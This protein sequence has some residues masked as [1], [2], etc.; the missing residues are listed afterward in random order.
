[1]NVTKLHKICK[2]NFRAS[3]E[4]YKRVLNN[5]PFGLVN[6]GL[7]EDALYWTII[8]DHGVTKKMFEY[9]SYSEAQITQMQLIINDYKEKTITVARRYGLKLCT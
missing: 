7:V 3:F 5:N 2:T 6:V 9:S 8:T 4:E 1:M